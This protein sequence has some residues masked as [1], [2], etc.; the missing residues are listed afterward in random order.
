[1]MKEHT[2]TTI[3]EKLSLLPDTLHLSKPGKNTLIAR[4]TYNKMDY[5]LTVDNKIHYSID[6]YLMNV[7][8]WALYSGLE[9][10]N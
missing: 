5:T 10:E 6:I 2:P 8:A 7:L 1:M 4:K 9:M 3:T